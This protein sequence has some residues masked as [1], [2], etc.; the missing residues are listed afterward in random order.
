MK[1]KHL[2][3]ILAVIGLASFVLWFIQG[4]RKVAEPKMT[5][6]EQLQAKYKSL[7]KQFRTADSLRIATQ[8]ELEILRDS[9]K[10]TPVK[11]KT[12]VITKTKSNEKSIPVSKS[13]SAFYTSILSKRYQR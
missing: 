8:F 10:N 2:L 11:T 13:A 4:T 1:L 7:E 5:A 6:I 9:I 3:V 12:V